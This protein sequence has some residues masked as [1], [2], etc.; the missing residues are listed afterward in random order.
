MEIS[1]PKASVAPGQTVEMQLTDGHGSLA[2]ESPK[3]TVAL[4]LASKYAVVVVAEDGAVAAH[5]TNDLQVELSRA[6]HGCGPEGAEWLSCMARNTFGGMSEDFVGRAFLDQWQSFDFWHLCN[7]A[8]P[9]QALRE[10]ISKTAGYK[11]EILRESPL[12][13]MIRGFA[14]KE[15]CRG[16]MDQVGA[17]DLVRAHVGGTGATSTSE[18]R[19]TLTKN[20]FVDWGNVN[21]LSSMSATMFDVVSELLGLKVPYEGQEPVNFLHYVKGFEYRPHTDG[22][23]GA[24]GKRVATTLVY[25][26]A[27]DVGGGTVFPAATPPMLFQPGPGDILFFEY[28]PQP[29]LGLHAACPVIEGN[30]STLTQWHRLGVSP[31]KPWDNF[32]NWGKFH[33]PYG[34]SRWTGP[35]YGEEPRSPEL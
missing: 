28:Q 15:I 13:A 30:K 5:D 27:A 22:A 7:A 9:T 17:D 34:K 18:A 10:Q 29:H 14:S 26:E 6:A 23:G 20:F 25:C 24:P 21:S 4:P 11:I 16:I 1:D 3:A 12:A 2:L 8:E 33:N 35:R 31:E 32:E 19:E